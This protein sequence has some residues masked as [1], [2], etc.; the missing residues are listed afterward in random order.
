[1]QTAYFVSLQC[2]AVQCSAVQCSAVQFNAVMCALNMNII[3]LC[4]PSVAHIRCCGIRGSVGYEQSK[5]RER[6]R[7][8]RR[9]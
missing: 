7:K 2:S 4:N 5:G 6:S 8:D 9:G 3:A 1:M